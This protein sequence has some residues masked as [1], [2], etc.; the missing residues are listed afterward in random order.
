MDWRYPSDKTSFCPELHSFDS[1][2]YHRILQ[3]AFDDGKASPKPKKLTSRGINLTGFDA[4]TGE[5][6]ETF[7]ERALPGVTV[8]EMPGNY[9]FF[10]TRKGTIMNQHG[11]DGLKPHLGSLEDDW[12]DFLLF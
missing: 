3:A 10:N 8:K 2:F 5:T 1:L 12:D 11:A 9:M 6:L 7:T 4:E